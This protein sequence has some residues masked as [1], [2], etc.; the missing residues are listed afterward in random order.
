VSLTEVFTGK[1]SILELGN[2]KPTVNFLYR[3]DVRG[4]IITDDE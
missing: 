2:F 4:A 3:Y 1:T